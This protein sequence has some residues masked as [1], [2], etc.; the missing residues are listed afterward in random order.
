M[1]GKPAKESEKT[2]CGPGSQSTRLFSPIAS[3]SKNDSFLVGNEV[4][5]TALR[6]TAFGLMTSTGTKTVIGNESC[7]QLVQTNSAKFECPKS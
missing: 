2:E 4:C 1:K 6:Q 7:K 5:L 3:A